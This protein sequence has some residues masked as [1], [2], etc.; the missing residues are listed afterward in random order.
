MRGEPV[1]RKQTMRTTVIATWLMP[2]S[3]LVPSYLFLLFSMD[4]NLNVYDEGIV[5][6]GANRILKGDIP[7]RDFWTSYGPG[8]YYALATLFKV[9]GSSVL[10]ERAWDILLRAGIAVIA[11]SQVKRYAGMWFAIA[12][13]FTALVALSYFKSYAFPMFPAL[14]FTL[15][16]ISTLSAT[17]KDTSNIASLFRAGCLV[18]LSTLFR[19]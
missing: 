11:Y 9:L 13:W 4:L 14:L 12:A 8:Q 10:L 15:L 19:H 5:L 3:L 16:S 18:G 17:L 7:Y 1:M 6:Y 2:I